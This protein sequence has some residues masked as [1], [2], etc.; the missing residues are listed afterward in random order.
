MRCVRYLV[1]IFGVLILLPAVIT[2]QTSPSTNPPK[3]ELY[4]VDAPE[5]IVKAARK[6]ME[7]DENVA[8]I[9]VDGK[10]QPRIRTVKAFL[11]PVDL[12]D[13]RKSMTVWVMTRE[14]T[15]KVEQ[16]RRHG[17][18]VL[19]FNDDTKVSYLSVMGKARL[20][21]DPENPKVKP[22]LQMEGYKEF[23]WPQFPK[24]FVMIEVVPNWIEF[25]GP[26]IKN[27]KE[28]WRPQAVEFPIK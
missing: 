9:T 4:R 27:H 7:A 21:T 14:S 1:S 22:F 16:I 15:R 2:A 19:Y 25:M 8:L 28:N 20:H 12:N 6:L 10:G 24:G 3:E 18:V 23:F 17:Q 5:A 26:G 13:S 11:N